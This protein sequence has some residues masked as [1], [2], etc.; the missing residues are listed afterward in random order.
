MN[1]L[2]SNF[3]KK[4]NIFFI[5]YF[6]L[7]GFASFFRYP[8]IKNELKYFII[9]DQ[10][11]ENKNFFVLKYFNELYP[12]KPPI[13]FWVLSFL[14]SISKDTF[15]PLGLILGGVIPAT[16]IAYL[17][18]KLSKTYWNE[19]MAYISTAIFITLPFIFG[20]TLVLRMDYFMTAFIMLS[21][22]IFFISYPKNISS[23]RLLLFYTFIAIG[24]LIK[25]GAAF[26]IPFLTILFYL[27]INTNLKYLKKMR[28]ISGTLIILSVLFLWF[29]LIQKSDNGAQYIKLILGQETIGRVI[30]SKA[31]I[32]PFYYY[33]KQLPFTLLTLIPFFS[34]GIF[35]SIKNIFNIKKWKTIDKIAFSIFF[36]NFIFFSTIS[37]K[38]DI[39]LLP[40][41]Y[42]MVIISL[43]FIEVKWPNFKY[44]IFKK[45]LYINI[46]SFII[47]IVALPY[48]TNNYTLKLVTTILRNSNGNI[49]SYRFPDAKNISLEIN[50]KNLKDLPLDKINSTEANSLIL[51]RNKY[52]DDI[53]N[54]DTKIIYQNKKY[55]ILEK[56][57][58]V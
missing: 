2:N 1:N 54:R 47:C 46:F 5:G 53:Y 7:I 39:Y 52:I 10:L 40:L 38:L 17:S 48:Y 19:K 42:G 30:K 11:I 20:T 12:D 35:F 29:F 22:Y 27:Y 31:H 34:L 32:R 23:K 21:L 57:N 36:P 44:K 45:I 4:Y 18:F 3:K 24:I 55:T 16:L 49:Y 37:G 50:R 8:D 43:R 25:G 6:M 58:E 33:L 15:Y 13:Y 14:R 41:Y 56:R 28:P 26:V 51:V 9:I